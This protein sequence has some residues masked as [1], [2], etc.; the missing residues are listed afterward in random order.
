M[1]LPH[2]D[3]DNSSRIGEHVPNTILGVVRIDRKEGA[4]GLGHCPR[5]G[6]RFDRPRQCKGDVGAWADS[7]VD[8]FAG[9]CVRLGVEFPVAHLTITENERRGIGVHSRGPAED[10]GQGQRRGRGRSPC[11]HKEL[12]LELVEKIEISDRRSRG[13]RCAR[14]DPHQ[15]REE[16]LD[17]GF[18]V[19]LRGVRHLEGAGI[20]V[21]V[22]RHIEAG[23]R[24]LL[25]AVVEMDVQLGQL[26]DTCRRSN[27]QRVAFSS[28]K[29]HELVERRRRIDLAAQ[30]RSP[31]LG[32]RSDQHVTALGRSRQQCRK[33][34]VD[35]G[36]E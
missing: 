7:P 21:D 17:R 35:N 15:S 30:R 33:C 28:K 32:P 6:H 26:G 12:T 9:E 14:K 20:R 4:A 2:A 1:V 27:Q 13:C 19:V 31:P 24:G 16:G 34:R 3:S 11:R 18:G 36:K 23:N 22:D 10:I 8:Q 5:R 29:T 25:R